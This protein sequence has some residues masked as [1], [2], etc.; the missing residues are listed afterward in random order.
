MQTARSRE[1]GGDRSTRGSARD[2]CARG[3]T[4]RDGT[5][6]RQ[7]GSGVVKTPL[8]QRRAGDFP[9]KDRWKPTRRGCSSSKFGKQKSARRI[10]APRSSWCLARRR[11]LHAD[12]C[13]GGDKAKRC[14][15]RYA[16][17]TD[18]AEGLSV[19]LTL[20][21][22][23][24]DGRRLGSK[25]DRPLNGAA[26]GRSGSKGFKLPA[27]MEPPRWCLFDDTGRQRMV[28]SW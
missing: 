2:S 12:A 24:Y 10:E 4:P 16:K 1:P 13:D 3:K 18:L 15:V 6:A 5:R 9:S 14:A 20:G 19:A 23:R 22:L 27:E 8:L 28:R 17:S 25:R 21:V 11:P 26:S 7:S